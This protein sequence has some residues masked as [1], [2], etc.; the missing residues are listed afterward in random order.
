MNPPLRLRSL[1]LALRAGLSGVV[2]A[3]ALGLWASLDHLRSAHE[4]LLSGERVA[5][6]EADLKAE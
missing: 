6:Q 3:L 5:I 2:L 4:A 1:P